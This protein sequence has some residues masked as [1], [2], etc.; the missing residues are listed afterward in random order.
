MADILFVE[1]YPLRAFYLRRVSRVWPGLAVYVAFCALR[2]TPPGYL[3]VRPVD[4][5]AALLFLSNYRVEFFGQSQVLD[6][7]WSLAVEE[8]S[9][10]VLGIL[11]VWLRQRREELARWVILALAVGMA[12][13]GI[14]Q[15]YVFPT[16]DVVLNVP[17]EHW[18]EYFNVYWRSDIHA[19]SV[20]VAAFIYLQFRGRL[21]LPL[22]LVVALAVC[23]GLS[24]LTILPQSFR[25]TVGTVCLGLSVCALDDAGNVLRGLLSRRVLILFG[26]WS[27]SIYVWQQIFY[28]LFQSMRAA[29]TL[30]AIEGGVLR[31]LFVL[32]A[33]GAGILRWPPETGQVA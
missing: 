19:A 8:H 10:I 2:F 16:R 17:A 1:K 32:G 26:T 14:A 25:F 12:A 18:H 28:K 11:A 27:Y 23:G 4:V 15:S 3:H 6:H 31:P 29:G 20:F 30:S 9:Y 22:G 7:T 24:F 21:A 13:N 5:A 33:C